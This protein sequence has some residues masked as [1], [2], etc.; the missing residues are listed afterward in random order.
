MG[1]DFYPRLT[2]AIANHRECNRLVNEQAEVSVL[3]A[4]PGILATLALTPLVIPLLYSSAFAEADD[5]LRWICLGAALQVVTWPFGYI[6]VAEGRQRTFFLCELAYTVSYLGIAWVLVARYGANGGAMAFLCSYVV[7][8]LIVYPIA[9]RHTGFRL[10]ARNRRI[11]GAFLAAI[12]LV[13]GGF[14]V[15]PFRLA[16]A[17]GLL[18]TVLSAVYSSRALL[19]YLPT[20]RPP[21]PVRRLL[22]L[23]RVASP[24][25][26][27]GRSR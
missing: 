22:A 3:L 15:L 5:L 23:A 2:A 8:G 25:G 9:R 11:V 13:F 19:V 18:A 24:R 17:V 12:G 16:T 4:G 10:S 7:H 1:T 27:A 26:K 14:Y 6:I 21:G 20:D